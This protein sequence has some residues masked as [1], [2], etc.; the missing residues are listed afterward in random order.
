MVTSISLKVGYLIESSA[1]LEEYLDV[2]EFQI[3][4]AALAGALQCSKRGPFVGDIGEATTVQ[5]QLA[6]S[7]VTVKT[8]A[9]C[10]AEISECTILET[11]LDIRVAE[12]LD[13]EVGAF[14]GYVF[15]RQEMDGGTFVNENPILDRVEYLSPLPLLPPPS[16][17]DVDDGPLQLGLTAN[18]GPITVSP[19]TLGAVLTIC[20]SFAPLSFC[21]DS[22]A[23]KSHH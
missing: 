16:E 13:P 19:W 12:G 23:S 22:D 14:L 8:G 7:I 9:P 6:T 2:L 1:P 21:K 17:S 10:T 5:P 18:D 15:L 4:R 20:K 11:N 3:L